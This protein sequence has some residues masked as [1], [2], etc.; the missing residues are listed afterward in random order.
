MAKPILVTVPALLLLLDF[1]P[2]ARLGAAADKPD[3][4]SG[5]ERP[6]LA[7]LVIEKIPLFALAAGEALMTMRTHDHPTTALAW[8]FRLSN[9]A[10]SCVAYIVQMFRPVDLA[11]YYP[12][13]T[14]GWPDW[15]VA[16]SVAILATVSTAVVV[17]R[18]RCPYL[19]VGWFWYLGML[20]PVLGLVQVAAHGMA[21]RYMYLPGIGLSIA[22]TWGAV[23]LCDGRPAARRLLAGVGGLVIA[24]LVPLA[25]WQTWL[26]RSDESLWRRMPWHAPPITA[27]P[28]AIW[29]T[30]WPPSIASTMRS[31]FI[32]EL[33][34]IPPMPRRSTTWECCCGAKAERT[35]RSIEFRQ[36]VATDPDDF[37]RR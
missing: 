6:G 1:W 30:R 32:V 21:D 37:L 10:V 36:A 19:L 27:R 24:L 18:R 34:S 29:P 8:S 26:W 16:A 14:A 31:L 12:L 3:W 11:I 17:W 25:C 4:T 15:Q 2:L 23:R 20:S 22:V 28:S 9:A 33:S 13:P 5:I 7:S 35:R